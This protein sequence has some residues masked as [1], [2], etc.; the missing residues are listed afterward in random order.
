M[1]D[2]FGFLSIVDFGATIWYIL[3]PNVQP[4]MDLWKSFIHPWLVKP[5]WLMRIENPNYYGIAVIFNYHSSGS[6][7]YKILLLHVVWYII[8]D[9]HMHMSTKIFYNLL[10]F[11]FKWCVIRKSTSH[12]HEFNCLNLVRENNLCMSVHLVSNRFMTL[13]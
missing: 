4:P 8:T 6:S 9:I 1:G 7:M 10:L 13:N 3:P 12:D 2:K 5:G 11:Y